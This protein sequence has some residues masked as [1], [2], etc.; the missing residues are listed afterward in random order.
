M[1]GRIIHIMKKT[2]LR[3]ALEDYAQEKAEEEAEIANYS[4]Y[5]PDDDPYDDRYYRTG[6]LD[7]VEVKKINSWEKF[8]NV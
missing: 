4:A 1:Y 8:K 7:L 6:Y 5:Y 3:V 2:K